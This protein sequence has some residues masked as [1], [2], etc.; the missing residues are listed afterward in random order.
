MLSLRVSILIIYWHCFQ[1]SYA[2]AQLAKEVN[3]HF[4]RTQDYLLKK[5][6]EYA[7]NW[8]VSRTPVRAETVNVTTHH[9]G[10]NIELLSYSGVRVAVMLYYISSFFP[11][12]L[13]YSR[14][15]FGKV[16]EGP[17]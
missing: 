15:F 8:L 14:D 9:V 10:C 6:R 17:F 16:T 1:V 7:N 5:Y 11:W 12:L 4:K 2:C 13:A 3:L